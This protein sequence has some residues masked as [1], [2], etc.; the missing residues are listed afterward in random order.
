MYNYFVQGIGIVATVLSVTSFQM[1]TKRMILIMQILTGI[2]FAAHYFL[3]PEGKGIAGG[4]V[5]VIAIV[6]NLV[7]FNR[8]KKFFRSRFWVVLFAV[9]M[10]A[11]AIISRFEPISVLMAI[12]MVFNT[13]AVWAEKPIDTRK[14]ILISSPFALVYNIAIKSS[15]MVNEAVVIIVTTITLI[16]ESRKE[17]C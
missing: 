2:V 9:V 11:S 10:A 17:K 4:V 5:N 6:R 14:R 3:M 16:R 15:G 13:L 7:F 8:N 12:A 1:K